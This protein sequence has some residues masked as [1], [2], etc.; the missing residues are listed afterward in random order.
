[1][2]WYYYKGV[3][4][5][6]EVFS[7]QWNFTNKFGDTAYLDTELARKGVWKGYLALDNKNKL[8]NFSFVW[9]ERDRSYSISN[10]SSLKPGLTYIKESLR[11]VYDSPN[12]DPVFVEFDIS[13]PRLA[14][15]YYSIKLSID[16]SNRTRQDYFQLGRKL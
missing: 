16:W 3:I 7:L 11:Q 4:Y 6:D 13:Q 12:V 8:D 9:V 2:K 15:R 10:T 5:L 1:M 14:E